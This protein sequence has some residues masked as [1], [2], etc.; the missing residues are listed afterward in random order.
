MRLVVGTFGPWVPYV[1]T[2]DGAD[3]GPAG[4]LV[5]ARARARVL[6]RASWPAAGRD[7]RLWVG[8]VLAM[9]ALLLLASGGVGGLVLGGLDAVV[10]LVLLFPATDR[11]SWRPS[12][13]GRSAGSGGWPGS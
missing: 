10:A 7:W 6:R 8:G 4:S 12:W 5:Q 11:M 13:A 2:R 1:T 9:L 3:H